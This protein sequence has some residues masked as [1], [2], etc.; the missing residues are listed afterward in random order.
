M[1]AIMKTLSDEN[2]SA[3]V[4][5]VVRDVLGGRIQNELYNDDCWDGLMS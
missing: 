1:M 5:E 2:R 4:S 3:L